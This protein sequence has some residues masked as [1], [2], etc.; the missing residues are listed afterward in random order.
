MHA[1]QFET[2]LAIVRHRFATTIESKISDAVVSADHMSRS[3]DGA[4]KHVSE[5]YRLLHD[6]CGI[7]P[8][9][10]FTATSEAARVAEVALMPAHDESRGP[11]QAEVR[12]LKVALECLRVAAASELQLMY[13]RGG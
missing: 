7:G 13:Q 9:A 12:S 11:T 8:T 5:S 6:I 3:G 1:D 10:G 2:R 4:T